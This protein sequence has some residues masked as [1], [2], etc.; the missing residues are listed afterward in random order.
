[1]GISK[2]KVM[3]GKIIDILEDHFDDYDEIAVQEKFIAIAT[4]IENL[5]KEYYPPKFVRWLYNEMYPD[6][7][8]E[9]YYVRWKLN[10]PE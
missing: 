6:E 4:A 2:T 3:R 9:E 1:L 5:Y 8:F 10:N 7:T